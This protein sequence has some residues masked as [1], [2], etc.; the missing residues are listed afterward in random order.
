M[1]VGQFSR[2]VEGYGKRIEQQAKQIDNL[3]HILGGY[4]ATGVNDPK[5]YPRKPKLAD[6]EEV[7]VYKSDEEYERI[8][9]MKYGKK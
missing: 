8:A 5:K 4:I 6:Q 3:N 7:S 9:R 1:T 2:C